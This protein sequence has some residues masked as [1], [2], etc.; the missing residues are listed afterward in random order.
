[1]SASP[2]ERKILPGGQLNPISEQANPASFGFNQAQNTAAVA[3]GI[4]AV[5]N[6]LAEQAIRSNLLARRTILEDALNQYE[7]E[8]AQLTIK[9]SSLV[10][11][12]AINS[13]EPHVEELNNIRK[14]YEDQ[15]DDERLRSQFRLMSEQAFRSSS[16]SVFNNKTKQTIKYKQATDAATVSQIIANNSTYY[17][18]DNMIPYNERKDQLKAA[19]KSANIGLTEDDISV[20]IAVAD[21][22][23]DMQ[24]NTLNVIAARNPYEAK[25][26]YNENEDD[27]LP[28]QRANISSKIDNV[29]ANFMADQK[30]QQVYESAQLISK[31]SKDL[32]SALDIAEKIFPDKNDQSMAKKEIKLQFEEEKARIE[33]EH[34]RLWEETYD[35]QTINP[36]TPIPSSLTGKEESALEVRRDKL[37]RATIK[38]GTDIVSDQDLLGE[39]S[40]ASASDEELAKFAPVWKT[41]VAPKLNIKDKEKW[42]KLINSANKIVSGSGTTLDYSNVNPEKMFAERAN[43]YFPIDDK[44]KV[45]DRQEARALYSDM[46]N[47][48]NPKTLDDYNDILDRLFKEFEIKGFFSGINKWSW[49]VSDLI[50]SGDYK[51]SDF[52][53]VERDRTVPKSYKF[54]ITVMDYLNKEGERWNPDELEPEK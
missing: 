40:T 27:F 26:F 22:V 30:K 14:K 12:Y 31:N 44:E 33:A 10:G 7:T 29:I 18:K 1:M 39:L 34:S 52:I 43:T 47:A 3:Q 32:S 6:T 28:S 17:D 51:A 25:D 41:E 35:K 23:H 49:A 37:K 50:E 19:V 20:D 54:N 21:A 2:L 11:R 53:E 48:E 5:E 4:G 24:V 16:N 36:D 8:V 9:N 38:G 13:F 46:I 42:G 15:L 45:V